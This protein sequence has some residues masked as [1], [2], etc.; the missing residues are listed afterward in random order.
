MLLVLAAGM[1]ATTTVVVDAQ[2][3]S[4]PVLIDSTTEESPPSPDG[5][6]TAE[7]SA[8]L[9]AT[10]ALGTCVSLGS[11]V[12][13]P[14]SVAWESD[15]SPVFDPNFLWAYG[16]VDLLWDNSVEDFWFHWSEATPDPDPYVVYRFEPGTVIEGVQITNDWSAGD[17]QLEGLD[18]VGQ[19]VAGVA[20]VP[21]SDPFESH[22]TQLNPMTVAAVKVTTTTQDVKLLELDFCRQVDGSGPNPNPDVDVNPDP[23]PDTDPDPNPNPNPASTC[24]SGHDSADAYCGSVNVIDSFG[25]ALLPPGADAGAPWN[26]VRLYY[27]SFGGRTGMCSIDVHNS[28]WTAVRNAGGE[29]TYYP[30]W[31]PP[32]HDAGGPE[33]CRFTH[34][35]GIDPRNSDLYDED[36]PTN[37]G[38]PFGFVHPGSGGAPG[39]VEDHVGHKIVVENDT[40]LTTNNPF[41]V[42]GLNLNLFRINGQTVTCD[43]YSK[44]HQ[45]THSPDAVSYTH[46]TL[47]TKA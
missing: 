34:E 42:A 46:L 7:P 27:A 20:V 11:S 8:S 29:L 31:H 5:T 24:G 32:I 17:L 9:N 47:P 35:H 4:P 2:E 18:G 33:E 39:R 44:L 22:A 16:D 36:L 30:S 10:A 1:I 21:L 43:W 3:S 14:N 12:V 15:S 19:P 13:E 45:G 28:Y 25:D 23:D 6:A 40:F 26:N 38:A 37:I 41:D